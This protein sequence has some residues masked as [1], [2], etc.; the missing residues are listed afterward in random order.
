MLANSPI[1]ALL[2]ILLGGSLG[3]KQE[4]TLTAD[5]LRSEL[6]SI[7][8]VA[9]ETKLFVAQIHEHRV[10]RAF[11]REHLNYLRDQNE[12]TLDDLAK[13]CMTGQNNTTLQEAR[14]Q[15]AE[16]SGQLSELS[17]SVQ[18]LP[19]DSVSRIDRILSQNQKLQASLK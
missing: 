5:E 11:A 10:T 1:Y 3:C 4:K 8:S 7:G 13:A 6:K 18:H 14:S 19:A 9:S 12:E 16:L 2:L 17:A 15:A